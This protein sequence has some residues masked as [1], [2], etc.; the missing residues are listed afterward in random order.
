MALIV[1][2]SVKGSPGVSTA[3]TALAASWPGPQWTPIVEM[4][5]AGGDLGVR[6]GLPP[7]AGLVELASAVRRGPQ[8]DVLAGACQ[9]IG[10]LGVDVVAAPPDPERASAAITVV[11]SAGAALL[12]GGPGT[13]VLAD[14]GRLDDSSPAWPLVSASD[15]LLVCAQPTVE[16]LSHVDSRLRTFRDRL[17]GNRVGLLLVGEGPYGSAEIGDALGTA[18]LGHLPF[19]RRA[20][21]ILNGGSGSGRGWERTALGKAATVAAQQIAD[22]TA[23]PV[24][25][26]GAP[27]EPSGNPVLQVASPLQHPPSSGPAPHT[28]RSP[29]PPSR[30][31][32]S[33]SPAPAPQP[34]WIVAPPGTTAPHTAA[35][36]VGKR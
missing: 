12:R 32:S 30:V 13:V 15:L 3:V 19:D 18:V 31:S 9:R 10:G 35:T 28:A 29:V 23:V 17:G 4:D 8:P 27:N 24:T 34:A 6:F 20:L 16:S 26:S 7:G 25:V 14:V 2:A 21:R 11:A 1:V 36:P 22:R 5:P 33:P